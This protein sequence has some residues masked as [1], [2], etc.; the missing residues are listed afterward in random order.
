MTI[1]IDIDGV[2]MDDD[3][4]VLDCTTK[5]AYENELEYFKDPYA[6]TYKKYNWSEKEINE[7]RELYLW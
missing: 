2:I 4:Y 6:L 7:Y 1:A 3:Q 5:Y